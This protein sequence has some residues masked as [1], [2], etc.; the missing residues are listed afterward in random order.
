M[1]Y[2]LWKPQLCPPQDKDK[3]KANL[4]VCASELLPM[5][6]GFSTSFE[7]GGWKT[8]VGGCEE[9]RGRRARGIRGVRGHAPPGNFWN[10]ECLWCIFRHFGQ[11]I[12][13]LRALL[14]KP[15]LP[16]H[17]KDILKNVQNVWHILLKIYRV[18]FLNV[19][20]LFYEQ[21]YFDRKTVKDNYLLQATVIN[22]ACYERI[23]LAL[24][25]WY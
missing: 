21:R 10:L 13:T 24:G 5:Y 4:W 11:E 19:W 20:H 17:Y 1:E 8:K 12:T 18:I 3:E 6:T 2:W 9:A 22:F 14:S 7:V 16:S 23:V 25:L 15:F